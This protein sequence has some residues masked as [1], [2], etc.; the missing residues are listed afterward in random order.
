MAF[1]IVLAQTEIWTAFS[2]IW[3]WLV[4]FISY[5]NQL[6]QTSVNMI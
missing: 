3:I 1:Q 5:D 4:E 2:R 6:H